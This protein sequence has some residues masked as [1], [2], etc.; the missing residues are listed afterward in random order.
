MVISGIYVKGYQNKEYKRYSYRTMIR[1]IKL[2]KKRTIWRV[3]YKMNFKYLSIKC[4]CPSEENMIFI[5]VVKLFGLNQPWLITACMKSKRALWKFSPPNRCSNLA[6]HNAY[7]NTKA[8]YILDSYSLLG[9][10]EILF[11]FVYFLLWVRIKYWHIKE[12]SIWSR[13]YWFSPIS[14]LLG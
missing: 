5:C 6:D 14:I 7:I 13:Y 1:A 11:C 9:T 8:Y 2:Q 3:L 12:T 10:S 4:A